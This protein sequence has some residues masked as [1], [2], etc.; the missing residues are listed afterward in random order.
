VTERLSFDLGHS[1]I[2]AKESD[3][4]AAE[5]FG[6]DGPTANG[7]FF[8]EAESQVHVIAAALKVKLGA[9]SPPQQPIITKKVQL[10]PSGTART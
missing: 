2:T 4:L 1:F 7:P 3:L 10:T 8:G 6:G 9:V 5:G